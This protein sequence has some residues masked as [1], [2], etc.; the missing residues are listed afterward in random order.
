MFKDGFENLER[1]TRELEAV[2]NYAQVKE[3]R[4]S[5]AKEAGQL[6]G[7]LGH[8]EVQLKSEV[9]KKEELSLRLDKSE[10]AVKELSTK[11]DEVA[12]ELSS[13]Q[14]LSVKLPEGS[15]LSLDEMK[16]QLLKAEED[17]IEGRAKVRLGELEKE[18]HSQMPALVYQRLIEIIKHPGLPP[19]IEEVINSHAKKI[20][21]DSLRDMDKWP[22][23]FKEYYSNEVKESVSWGLNSE[24]EKRVQAEAERKLDALKAGQW[25]DYTAH[26]ARGLAVD[27]KGLV[28]QLQGTWR[29]SCDRCGR[30]LSVN[31]SAS[32]IGLL[33]EGETIDITCTTCLDPA[34]FPFILS[35]VRHKVVGLSL[36]GL[37]ELYMGSAPPQEKDG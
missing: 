28:S 29:F 20:T 12:K 9:R 23:W 27:L 13:L 6:K 35:T 15:A 21:D 32:D 1:Y 3:D 2:K 37:L 14:N 4:D 7:K 24:F 5:L 36:G 34:P 11:L 16:S 8:L 10:A 17:E 18:L 26:K 19:E 25:R 31:L 30:G 33:L 22:D